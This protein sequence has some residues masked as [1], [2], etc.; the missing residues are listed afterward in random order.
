MQLKTNT[1][2]ILYTTQNEVDIKICHVTYPSE[3][4]HISGIR[5]SSMTCTIA[6]K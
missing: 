6:L 2:P 4:A 3:L 1:N 5:I